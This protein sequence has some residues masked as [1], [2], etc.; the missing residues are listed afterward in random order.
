MIRRKD[1]KGRAKKNTKGLRSGIVVAKD[2]QHRLF[3]APDSHM[4]EE[5]K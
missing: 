1:G 4:C 3:Y 2:L 5:G